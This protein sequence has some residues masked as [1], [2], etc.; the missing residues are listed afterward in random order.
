MLA[1]TSN[2]GGEIKD[3]QIYT[4]N[5]LEYKGSGFVAYLAGNF[6]SLEIVLLVKYFKLFMIRI[7]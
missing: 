6:K 2:D 5:S 1:M 4:L 7:C 3:G